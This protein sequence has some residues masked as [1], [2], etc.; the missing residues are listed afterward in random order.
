[1][2]AVDEHCVNKKMETMSMTMVSSVMPAT[3]L[4]TLIV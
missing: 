3:K 4:S 2:M 1:M